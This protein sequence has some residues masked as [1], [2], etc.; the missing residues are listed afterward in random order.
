MEKILQLVPVDQEQVVLQSLSNTYW[1]HKHH[2]YLLDD[3]LQV[4]KY[5]YPA[6][7]YPAQE[8]HEAER[9][10]AV[11]R[12]KLR[13]NQTEVGEKLV[14]KK[15]IFLSVCNQILSLFKT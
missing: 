9:G 11:L 1:D 7:V 8:M 12:Y 5:M 13:K 3:A 15:I 10:S 4:V 14:C 6:Q 2:T